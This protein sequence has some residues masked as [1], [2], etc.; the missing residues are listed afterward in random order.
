M[1]QAVAERW[2]VIHLGLRACY[3]T[4]A[5]HAGEV[6]PQGGGEQVSGEM[7]AGDDVG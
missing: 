5:L 7:V 4:V 2:A 3:C 1:E 6:A